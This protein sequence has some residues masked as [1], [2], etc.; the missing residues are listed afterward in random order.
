MLQKK[1]YKI[2]ISMI[3]LL[4]ITVVPCLAV[5]SNQIGTEFLIN[6]SPCFTYIT[7]FTSDL[8]ISSNGTAYISVFASSRSCDHIILK[9]FLQKYES[10][11]WKT[12]ETWSQNQFGT[13]VLLSENK[14]VSKGFQYRLLSNCEVYNATN[15]IESESMTTNPQFH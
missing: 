15:M 10:G 14:V 6:F 9:V 12:I 1:I 3:S 4:A 7:S 5:E 11:D 13:Y 2:V 8:Q